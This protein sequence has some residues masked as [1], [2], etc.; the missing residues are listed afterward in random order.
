MNELK[1][2][3]D[4]EKVYYKKKGDIQCLVLAIIQN[5]KA[6]AVNDGFQPIRVDNVTQ[7]LRGKIQSKNLELLDPKDCPNYSVKFSEYEQEQ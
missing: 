2:P 5:G 3:E 7:S 4:I 6:V 1:I